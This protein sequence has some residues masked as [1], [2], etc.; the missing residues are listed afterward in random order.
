MSLSSNDPQLAAVED[1]PPPHQLKSIHCNK[2]L[3]ILQKDSVSA[4]QTFMAPGTF[5]SNIGFHSR[6]KKGGSN[7]IKRERSKH[8]GRADVRW[9]RPMIKKLERD[10]CDSVSLLERNCSSASLLLQGMGGSATESHW[11]MC[12]SMSCLFRITVQGKQQG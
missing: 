1:P 10:V 9:F 12:L 8:Q 5:F 6:K 11:F 2:L 7:L 4:Q 3:V